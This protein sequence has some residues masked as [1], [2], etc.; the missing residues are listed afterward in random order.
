VVFCHKH[1]E[2]AGQTGWLEATA[3]LHRETSALIP[4]IMIVIII[5][6]LCKNLTL[7]AS[8]GLS[9]P[10]QYNSPFNDFPVFVLPVG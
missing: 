7:S 4:G 3:C 6:M 1:S 5:V 10:S 2:G 9:L 8:P